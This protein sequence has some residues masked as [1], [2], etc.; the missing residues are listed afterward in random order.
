MCPDCTD[1]HTDN[2]CTIPCKMTTNCTACARHIQ[3]W[4]PNIN[5][6]LPFVETTRNLQHLTLDPVCPTRIAGKLVDTASTSEQQQHIPLWPTV[7][8]I[9]GTVVPIMIRKTTTQK[10]YRVWWGSLP[11]RMARTSLCLVSK[12]HESNSSS[13]NGCDPTI[14]LQMLTSNSNSSF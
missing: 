12:L 6:R 2:M 11:Q 10:Q 14:E 3:A 8:N 4:E 13:G 9:R 5:L 1:N 7:G